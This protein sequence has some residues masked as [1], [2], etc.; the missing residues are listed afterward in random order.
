MA[1]IL[2]STAPFDWLLLAATK[3]QTSSYRKAGFKYK[4]IIRNLKNEIERL[5]K[6]GE[7]I[8][9]SLQ[10]EIL[11][12]KDQ[13]KEKDK[14]CY[15]LQ[16]E[17]ETLQI[18]AEEKTTLYESTL[19]SDVK[20]VETQESITETNTTETNVKT[21]EIKE[22]PLNETKN[23][24]TEPNT[25]EIEKETKIEKEIDVESGGKKEK[26]M[27]KEFDR[28]EYERM[29]DLEMSSGK[30]SK[31]PKTKRLHSFSPSSSSTSESSPLCLSPSIPHF[32]NRPKPG[33]GRNRKR[34]KK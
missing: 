7:E 20:T 24:E 22:T 4:N 26:V 17:I 13:L 9:F 32:T 16:S 29:I 8:V 30:V 31:V 34:R 6:R 10:D 28:A 25:E 2:P 15:E 1:N 33:K 14:L 23:K 5:T 3:L 21:T 18:D 12:L 11:R 19:I 27:K